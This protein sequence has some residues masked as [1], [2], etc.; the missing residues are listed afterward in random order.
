M[1][2]DRYTLDAAAHL[3]FRYGESHPFRFQIGLVERFSPRPL[4]A[5]FV[6]VSAETAHARK[7]EQYS[8]ED[9]TRQARLYRQEAVGLS[10]HRLD[11]ERPR[12]ELCAEIAEDVW[13][14]L[15]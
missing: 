15:G 1:I 4:K 14:A 13:R 10:V 12:E 6:D 3:R 2:C 11:G 7:A 5:Y 8:L 9:L